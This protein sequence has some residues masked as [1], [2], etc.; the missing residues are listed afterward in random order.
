[1]FVPVFRVPWLKISL[2]LCKIIIVKTNVKYDK[3]ISNGGSYSVIACTFEEESI[4][5]V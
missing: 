5:N 4:S 1:M 3:Y 2:L